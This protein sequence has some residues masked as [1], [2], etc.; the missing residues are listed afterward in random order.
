M[1]ATHSVNSMAKNAVS[2]I[3]PKT[4]KYN[5]HKEQIVIKR[6][7]LTRKVLFFYF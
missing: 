5:I 6:N 4:R 2:V 7:D 3:F 1:K